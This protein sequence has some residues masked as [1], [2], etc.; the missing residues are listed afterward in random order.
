MPVNVF[1]R[2]LPKSSDTEFLIWDRLSRIV[3]FLR[4]NNLLKVIHNQQA[5]HYL[6][7]CSSGN[8]I[9]RPKPPFLAVCR[10]K[11]PARSWTKNEFKP[12]SSS[13][14]KRA[15]KIQP[16][17]SPTKSCACSIRFANSAL[18]TSKCTIST[19]WSSS[20]WNGNTLQIDF[21]S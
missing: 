1:L 4:E 7:G 11:Q 20:D 3:N 10:C 15:N 21:F 8:R 17:C 6:G 5:S 2:S 9:V 13:Q 14:S 19:S 18:K 16:S 12:T